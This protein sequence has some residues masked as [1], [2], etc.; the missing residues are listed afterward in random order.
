[1][2]LI[3]RLD[4]LLPGSSH[5]V[6]SII[7]PYNLMTL[8]YISQ[9]SL[10]LFSNV[11]CVLMRVIPQRHRFGAAVAI[12][13]L[14][15]HNL[16]HTWSP[17]LERR[18]G[19]SSMREALLGVIL[20][21]MDYRKIRFEPVVATSLLELIQESISERRGVLLVGIHSNGG[22]SR[23]A[24]RLLHD[25][26]VP[27]RVFSSNEEYPVCG[28]GLMIPALSPNGSFLLKVRTEFRNA[29]L[30]C[31]MIDAFNPSAQ[32]ALE[33]RGRNGSIWVTDSLIRLALACEAKIIFVA[34]RL[35]RDGSILINSQPALEVKTPEDCRQQLVSFFER[36]MTNN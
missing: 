16:R 8:S 24:L 18:P 4:G 3:V 7:K 17:R 30:V 22:L 34:G 13:R 28:A 27:L 36:H 33:L 32:R 2:I 9:L 21:A 11:I 26:N 31:G 1:L 15:P 25:A 20:E 23:A 10:R 12:V 29:H 14:L 5:R 19:V 35:A 6:N